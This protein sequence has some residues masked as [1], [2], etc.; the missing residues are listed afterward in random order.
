MSMVSPAWWPDDATACFEDLRSYRLVGASA[1]ADRI[2]AALV[3]VAVTAQS[4]HREI[5]ADLH[6]AGRLFCDLKPD[7]ALYRNLVTH[8]VRAAD[9]GSAKHVQRSA[10]EISSYR[11]EAQVSVISRATALLE[12]ADTLLVHDYSSMVCRVLDSLGA[13]RARRIVV[14]SCEL[15]G[16][17]VSVARRAQAAGHQV[18]FTPDMSVSRVIEEVDGYVTG[19]ESFYADGSLA[20]TVGTRMLALLCQEVGVPVVAPAEALKYDS[21]RATVHDAELTAR[22]L[23]RWPD[24][25]A[26]EDNAWDTVQFVLDAVSSSLV[27]LYATDDGVFTAGE[28]GDAARK[29]LS[30]ELGEAPRP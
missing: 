21:T 30:R 9:A 3:S 27:T 26:S 1:C 20:N 4:S 7:T 11:R 24:A 2:T 8:L 18:T 15:L 16:K 17:G 23:R 19:V 14:T 6:D 10:Q 29:V 12:D 28:V 13:L 5:S 25:T 22:L